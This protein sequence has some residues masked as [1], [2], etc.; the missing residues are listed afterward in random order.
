MG[1]PG[2]L[3]VESGDKLRSALPSGLEHGAHAKVRLL[4]RTLPRSVINRNVFV[5]RDKLEINEYVDPIPQSNIL[6]E[7]NTQQD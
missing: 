5:E 2:G 4:R 1:L 7:A 6:T 3:V